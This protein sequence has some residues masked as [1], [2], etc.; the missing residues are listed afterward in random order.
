MHM[1]E[2][3]V[4]NIERYLRSSI[5]SQQSLL[6]TDLIQQAM[7]INPASDE[8]NSNDILLTLLDSLFIS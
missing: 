5:L 8:E 4:V 1:G 6:Q 7:S 2:Y 3:D